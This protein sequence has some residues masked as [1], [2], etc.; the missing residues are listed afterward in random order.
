MHYR[1]MGKHWKKGAFLFIMSTVTAVI[2]MQ[3]LFTMAR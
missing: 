2:S 3:K 1:D